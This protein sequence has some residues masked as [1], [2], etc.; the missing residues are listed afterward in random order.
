M[1]NLIFDPK[2]LLWVTI[3]RNPNLEREREKW[4]AKGKWE[5]GIGFCQREKIAL[6]FRFFVFPAKK[7]PNSAMES[8]RS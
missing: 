7:N 1:E 2:L 6:V 4:R 3:H 8:Q 5:A